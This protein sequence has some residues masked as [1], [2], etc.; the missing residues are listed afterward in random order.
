MTDIGVIV[1]GENEDVQFGTNLQWDG[2]PGNS[3]LTWLLD[4]GFAG[5]LHVAPDTLSAKLVT[6]PGN[7][8]AHVTVTAP[9]GV[10]D[11]ATVERIAGAITAIGLN[12]TLVTK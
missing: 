5:E 3:S 6:N 11:S 9:S 10:S 12:A 7:F 8:S 4:S 2:T 1:P